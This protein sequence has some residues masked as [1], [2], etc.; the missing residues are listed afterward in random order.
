[1]TQTKDDFLEK[2][3]VKYDEWLEDGKIS[4][5]SRVIPISE[6]FNAKQWVLPSEQAEEIVRNAQ[7]I[8]VQD[9]ECRSHYKRC[10]HPLEVCLLF[11]EVGSKLVSRNEARRIS[12]NESKELLKKADDSGLIHLA[13]YMPDHK[14]YALCSCCTCCCHELQIVKQYDR[15][16]IL[17]Q[18]DYVAITDFDICIHC[19]DCVERCFFE[20]R[21]FEEDA[22]KYHPDMCLGCGLCVSVCP[23]EATSMVLRNNL[24][25]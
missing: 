3:I 10:D 17:V 22:M 25:G 14:I 12:F 8:A 20:A 6:S 4:F 19:G 7:F 11:D 23:V 13:L 9:C 5:S 2:R 21:T 15:S 18:S 1:M 16:D 24:R